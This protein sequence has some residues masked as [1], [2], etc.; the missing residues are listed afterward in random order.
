MLYYSFIKV[1]LKLHT[2]CKSESYKP[3]IT[4]SLCCPA[5]TSCNNDQT[6]MNCSYAWRLLGM[7]PMLKTACCRGDTRYNPA[8]QSK[9]RTRLFNDAT[10]ILAESLQKLTAGNQTKEQ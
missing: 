1:I 4:E 6:V 3:D 5:V 2:V 9:R 7:C 10:S 8:W